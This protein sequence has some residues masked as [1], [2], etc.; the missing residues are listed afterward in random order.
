VEQLVFELVAPEPPTFG[1]FVAGRNAEAIAALRR[2]AAGSLAETGIVLWGPPGV[3]KSHLVAATA[4]AA[5]EAARP[6]LHCLSPAEWP[7]NAEPRALVALDDIASADPAAQA[8]LFTLY[9]ALRERG[10]TLVASADVP[11]ARLPFRDDVRTRLGWGLAYEIV[12]LADEE[13]PAALAAYARA[14][15]FALSD[16]VIDYLLAYGRRDMPTLVATLAA[17]DRR[18]L[19]LKRPVTVPLLR[20]WLQKSIDET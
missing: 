17:L 9:N 10:G 3:G 11:P 5:R 1:S 2:A 8:R 19:A 18:S 4:A 16:E 20:E 15:G 6:V 12:P 13:K 14:R 7:A